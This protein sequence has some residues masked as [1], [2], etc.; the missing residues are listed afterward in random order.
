M[1]QPMISLTNVSF[2]YRG[3]ESPSLSSLSL[4]VGAG[5]CVLL[6]GK[7]GCG[8][9]TVLRLLN[10]M[11]PEFFDGDLTGRVRVGGMDPT[12]CPQY[13]V[14]RRV[15]TVFQ[16]PRTQFY[17]LDTTSEVAFGCENRGMPRA[18]ISRRVNEAAADLGIAALMNRNIFRLSGGEK[19]RVAIAS[20]YATGPEVLLLDEPSANL[21]FP[22]IRELRRTLGILRSKGKTILVAEH[23]TWYLEGIV[24]RAVYLDGGKASGVFAMGELA[25]LT[26]SQRLETGIRPVKLEG[27]DLPR[28]GA[29]VEHAPMHEM[30]LDDLVFSYSR[31]TAPSLSVADAQFGS[32]RVEAIVGDNGAGKSTLASVVCGL[33][34]ERR[35][36]AEIDGSVLKAKR[37]LPI[38]YEVMQEVNHQLFCDSVEEE[39]I[40]GASHPG[41]QALESVLDRMDLLDVRGRH[42]LTLSGGQKQRCAIAA[43]MFCG[44]RVMAFD[45]PTSGLDYA[46]MAQ[47]AGLLR[48]LAASGVF[49]LVVTH[50][51]E[52]AL[53]ACDRVTE[54]EGGK[55]IAQYGLDAGGAARLREFFGIGRSSAFEAE[56]RPARS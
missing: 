30:H 24:D 15:G 43:A 46:H 39:I 3:A 29:P 51:Y 7:S 25:S 37:R 12:T 48:E 32:G 10:G 45:E 9:S 35:G 23:R 31:H 11:I 14:A 42:P 38:S 16:N 6:C 41:A 5:E 21:D 56:R 34:Q 52:L 36:R 54:M 26:R 20:V 19:Q 28:T 44:K 4:D 55:A 40:L 53:A 50:D 33:A 18:E 1:G 27:F 2:S 49:V 13:K 8:K 22:A 17:T 47:T